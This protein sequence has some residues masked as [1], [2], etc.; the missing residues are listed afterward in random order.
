MPFDP[1]YRVAELRA[2]EAGAAGQPLMERAGLAAAGVARELLAGRQASVLVLAGPGNNGGD[3]FVVARWLKSWFFDV[4]LAF[5]GDV[6]RLSADAASAHRSW[7][8]AGG[9]TILE[10]PDRSEFGLIVDGLFGIGLTRAVDGVYANW[11]SRANDAGVPILALDV[12]SGLD[13]DTGVA[14]TPT[15]RACATATFIALK[16]GM[17]TADGPDHCG[18]IGVHTLELDVQALAPARGERVVW[19]SLH[20]ELPQPLLRARK[21][22]HKG[23]FGMLA[24]VGGGDGMVGAAILAG[25]AA[26]HLGAGKVWVGLA[27]SVPP[28]LDWAQPELMLRAADRVLDDRPDALVI[29]PGLGTGE[30]SLSLLRHALTLAIP[31]VIDAD[32]LNLLAADADLVAT[33]A[34]RRAPTA[35][36]PHPA[37]A[38][39]L[40]GTT[41]ESIQGD[42]LS[43]ALALATKLNAAVVL[44]GAGSVL[45]FPDQSWAI[46]ISGN[47]GLASG[48]TGDVLAGMLGALLAQGI[49]IKAALECAVCLHGAAADALVASGVGPLG[50][51]A[52]ELAPM[53]RRLINAAQAER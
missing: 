25:R 34:A 10:W 17:L 27:A 41:T 51:V 49:P 5:R 33:V 6:A 22:V 29:G 7:L 21:N 39:R 18:A 26:L 48:G 42:R 35:V 3:A 24:I 15:I 50:M 37:E 12:P 47:Q 13:A 46:N 1:V 28:A 8:T 23:T 30:S 43:A 44:K 19:Q 20:R 31:T 9:T 16:P 45:A 52:S 38:A 4:V 11:I 14:H 53:A 32:A 36:T 2:L 40:S